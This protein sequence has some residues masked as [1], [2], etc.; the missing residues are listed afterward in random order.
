MLPGGEWVLFTLAAGASWDEAHIVVQSV[1]TG[2]RLVLVEGGRD[3]RYVATGHVVYVLNNV[4]FAVPFDVGTRAVT[5]GAV[6]L[7]EG[8]PVSLFTGAAHFALSRTGSLVYLTGL[9]RGTRQRDLVWV[10][11]T[12][13]VTPVGAETRSYSWQRV[14]PDGTRLAVMVVAADGNE[15]VWTY[16][17]ARGALTRMTFDEGYDLAPDWT[18]DGSRVVFSSEREGGGL[19]WKAADGTGEVERL[20]DSETW[21]SQGNWS[22]DGRLIVGQAGNIGVVTLEGD[23]R[24]DLLLDEEFRERNPALSPDGRWLAYESNESGQDEVYVR[25]FPE[26]ETGKWQV[27]VNGGSLPLW[28]PDGAELFFRTS[29]TGGQIMVSQ[30]EGEPTFR[31]S[32][33]ERLF[34]VADLLTSAFDI[35]PDG[36]RFLF[37]RPATAQET[38]D[39]EAGLVFVEHW[40]EE[41]KARVPTN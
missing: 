37:R 13:D 18:P 12:G 15:D 20:V 24:L 38:D 6:S 10:N 17:L 5:G 35:A 22:P 29:V 31:A 26:V 16:D 30:V 23:R 1:A 14:S 21:L 40:F 32:A 28:S 9:G 41:L 25:P 3:A 11:R 8:V 36:E 7:V 19:F 4:L 39:G 27:S 33:P 2:E 34:D